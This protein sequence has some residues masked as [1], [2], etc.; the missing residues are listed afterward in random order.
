MH[1]IH[2]DQ[3]TEQALNCI[4]TRQNLAPDT[5]IKN[6]LLEYLAEEQAIT[7]ADAAYKNY[8]DG[9]ESIHDF[10]DVVKVIWGS[11]QF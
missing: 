8:L 3:P 9:K 6:A 4:A 7:K 10:D 1:T 11:K 5:I 2:L